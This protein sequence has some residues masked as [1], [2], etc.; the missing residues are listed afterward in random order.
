MGPARD[1]RNILCFNFVGQKIQPGY[2]NMK[3]LHS[4]IIKTLNLAA[5]F[6]SVKRKTDIIMYI[7]CK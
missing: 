7:F 1:F 6:I 5:Q 2:P 4:E 3:A